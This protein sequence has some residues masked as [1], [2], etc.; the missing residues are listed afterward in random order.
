MA[1]MPHE[2]SVFFRSARDVVSEGVGLALSGEDE[3]G[4][5]PSRERMVAAELEQHLL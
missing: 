2:D 3:E 1:K 4:A 5:L